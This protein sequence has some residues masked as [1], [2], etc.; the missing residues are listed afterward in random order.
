MKNYKAQ[1]EIILD[2]KS[3]DSIHS[4]WMERDRFIPYWHFHPEI[5]LT[6][7]AKGKGVR[8][9][10]DSTEPF[11]EMDLVLLG[12]NLPHNWISFEDKDRCEA[13]VLQFSISIFKQ[14]A[15]L[16]QIKNFLDS[17][18]RGVSFLQPSNSILAK[19]YR[20]NNLPDPLKYALL[21]EMLYEL[22][23]DKNISLLTSETYRIPNY[24]AKSQLRYEKVT[25]YVINH[26]DRKITL[27]E[28]ANVANMSRESFSRWFKQASGT[29]F[30]SYLNKTKIEVACHLLIH[31]DDHINEVAYKV[32]FESQSQFHRCFKN[33]K[34]ISPLKF[35]KQHVQ[36]SG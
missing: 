18:N 23:S 16:A 10:G 15:E 28:I 25:E 9:V 17:A 6:F 3:S 20:Y 36:W 33:F 7:I 34:A 35:R 14:S 8:I 2:E 24:N 4:F 5:E 29:S 19:I 12:S 32:G 27:L 31:T 30:I 26:I 22:Q 11:H 1:K 13:F 21:I